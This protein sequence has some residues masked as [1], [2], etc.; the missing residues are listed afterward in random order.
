M[1]NE[2]ARVLEEGIALRPLDVDVVK[3]FGYGFPRWRG[4]P[5]QFAD[6]IGLATVLQKIQ[7]YEKEDSYFWKPSKLLKKLADNAGKF[8]DLN[9]RTSI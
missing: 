9:K 2:A 1:I 4:G 3:V 6:E 5:M 8:A 7:N